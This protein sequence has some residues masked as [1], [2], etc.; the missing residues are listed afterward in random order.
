MDKKEI[1]K[2]NKLIAEFM[3]WKVSKKGIKYKNSL[4]SYGYVHCHIDYLQFHKSWDWLRPVVIK[5]KEIVD[6][7]PEDDWQDEGRG[8]CFYFEDNIIMKDI[9]DV[10]NE[11][12][13]FVKWK[14][15]K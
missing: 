15:I 9:E 10:Y 11:V 13:R 7:L 14:R 8:F 4:P 5:I 12:V 3:G 6:H 1:I 2:N